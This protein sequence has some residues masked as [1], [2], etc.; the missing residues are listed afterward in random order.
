MVRETGSP[1]HEAG[2]V[3]LFT[4]WDEPLFYI[5]PSTTYGKHTEDAPEWKDMQRPQ[6]IFFSWGF[7]FAL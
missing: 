5:T 3:E 1:F 2:S 6:I 4:V 7:F